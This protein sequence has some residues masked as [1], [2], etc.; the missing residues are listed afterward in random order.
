MKPASIFIGFDPRE[1]D[2]YAVAR[3]SIKRYLTQQI[4]VKGLVLAHL[5][6]RGL[7]KRPIEYRP[8]AADRPV[9]W[10]VISDAPMATQFAVS[11]FFVPYLAQTGL[12]FFMDCDMLVLDNVVRL[13]E[14]CQDHTKAVWVV[15]HKHNPKN[16]TKMDGQVQT[17]YERKNWSSVM[18]FNC[19]HV[20]NK[21]LDL[22]YLNSARGLDL[23]QFKWLAD[24]EIGEIDPGWNFL[25]GHSDELIE[26]KIIHF[27]DG[28]PS[29]A[30]YENCRFA[31]LWR[32]ELHDW[33]A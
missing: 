24:S 14:Q 3:H 15:K 11:R 6:A 33:A 22:T 29:M 23:H 13:L 17:T 21:Q 30:G 9:M 31:D 16:S 10:D 12:A 18:V 8:S 19:D 32:H 26:P 27:T 28:V 4:P 20:A 7:Y 25:V 2:A 5:Q 1:S